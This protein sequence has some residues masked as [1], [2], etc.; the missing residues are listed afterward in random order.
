MVSIPHQ[1]TMDGISKYSRRHSQTLDYSFF[2]EVEAKALDFLL[3]CILPPMFLNRLP[4]I[5]VFLCQ[6]SSTKCD[7]PQLWPWLSLTWSILLTTGVE[8]GQPIRLSWL[9]ARA[10][11]KNPGSHVTKKRMFLRKDFMLICSSFMMVLRTWSLQ[12]LDQE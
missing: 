4:P 9:S 10:P 12:K 6:L 7:E 2:M 3:F 1:L 5:F 8:T 11:S